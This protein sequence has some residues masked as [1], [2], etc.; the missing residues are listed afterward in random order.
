MPTKKVVKKTAK[1]APA[2][3]KA[4]KKV[5]KKTAVKK[6]AKKKVA[7]KAPA[8]KSVK[9]TAKKAVKAKAS[10]KKNLVYA[11]EDTSFWVNNG[12][13]LNSLVALKE[14]LDQMEKEVY[15]YH[16]G[17]QH[18]D[19]SNWV[20]TVLSDAKCAKDLEKAKTPNSAKT[21]VVK[22]LKSYSV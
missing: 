5:S 17:G 3:K 12:E 9:K 10:G 2:P 15:A 13:I 11:N 22:H 18:N 16:A 8:K 21:V 20:A 6:T 14:A 7:K 19:F 1:K 4:V